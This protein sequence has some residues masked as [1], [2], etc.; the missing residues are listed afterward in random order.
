MPDNKEITLFA[1]KVAGKCD[2]PVK[3]VFVFL[4]NN[5]VLNGV[6]Y[7]DEIHLVFQGKRLPAWFISKYGIILEPAIGTCAS[8][9]D[10]NIC[11]ISS[12]KDPLLSQRV[13][14][15]INELARLEKF[16]VFRHN[17]IYAKP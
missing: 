7:P 16:N 2:L 14:D 5:I 6:I 12:L 13:Y 17:L 15:T 1:C 10:D 4:A 3:D 11:R 8:G 9:F